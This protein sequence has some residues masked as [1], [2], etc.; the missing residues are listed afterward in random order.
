MALTAAPLPAVEAAIA[1][2][3]GPPDARGDLRAVVL[4]EGRSDRAALAAAARVL[5][6]DLARERVAVV[7]MDGVTNLV[8][9]ATAAA[10]VAPGV[11]LAALVDAAEDRW[12]RAAL[13]R[14]PVPVS[15]KRCELDLEDE[16]LRA[17]GT[18]RALDVLAGSGDL[19]AFRMLQGQPAQRFRPVEAQLHRFLGVASGRKERLAA[20][21]TAA[22]EPQQL[23]PPIAAVLAA[24]G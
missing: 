8:R 18:S 23:P 10:T 14:I 1:R 7:A 24:T 3:A 19:A 13:P 9:C 4:V 17:L 15:L 6:R 12:V 5:G 11:P 2:A 21:L 16:L 22:L 20:V